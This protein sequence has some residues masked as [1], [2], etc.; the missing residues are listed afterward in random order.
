MGGVCRI[1]VRLVCLGSFFTVVSLSL[2]LLISS[3]VYALQGPTFR[4]GDGVTTSI[5][6]GRHDAG[7]RASGIAIHRLDT[8]MLGLSGPWRGGPECPA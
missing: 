2:L 5:R 4:E 7:S 8:I 3:P 6:A 1:L